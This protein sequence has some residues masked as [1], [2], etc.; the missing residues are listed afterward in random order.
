MTK[1]GLTAF[2]ILAFMCGI[3][4]S[5]ENAAI[6]KW[7]QRIKNHPVENNNI[8][9]QLTKTFPADEEKIFLIDAV[10][11]A[12]DNKWNIYV[13]DRRNCSIAVFNSKGEYLH[14]FGRRGQGPGDLYYPQNIFMWKNDIVVYEAGNNRIQFFDINGKSK[15]HIKI[16]K[17]YHSIILSKEGLI[18][19]IPRHIIPGTGQKMIDVINLDGMLVNSFGEPKEL[20]MNVEMGTSAELCFIS[21]ETEI[22]LVYNFIPIIERYS[23]NGELLSSVRISN[24]IIDDE[25]KNNQGHLS[26]GEFGLWIILPAVRTHKN[27]TY[28]LH[29]WPRVEILELNNNYNIETNFSTIVSWDFHARDF[30]VNRDEDQITIYCIP[31]GSYEHMKIHMFKT[32]K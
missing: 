9:I 14:S 7:K 3:A 32:K 2:I 16:F 13:A 29:S 28:L 23:I 5:Q 6:E 26:K 22:L 11:L 18:Y 20:L 25:A 19:G 8:E 10:S 12:H 27:K 17:A 24:P 15:K 4:I 1:K 30:L 21:D 31:R